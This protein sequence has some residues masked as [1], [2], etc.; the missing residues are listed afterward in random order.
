[1]NHAASFDHLVGAARSHVNDALRNRARDFATGAVSAVKLFGRD[2]HRREAATPDSR[3]FGPCLGRPG[4][5]DWQQ[6]TADRQTS[7][8]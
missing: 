5:P 4:L 6:A 8:G 7:D 3:N 2:L 1:M